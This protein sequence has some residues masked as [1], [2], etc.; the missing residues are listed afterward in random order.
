ME[1]LNRKRQILEKMVYV[2][3][4]G[5]IVRTLKMEVKLRENKRYLKY[6]KQDSTSYFIAGVRQNEKWFNLPATIASI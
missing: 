5:S 1:K 2:S 3:V 6:I 4:L